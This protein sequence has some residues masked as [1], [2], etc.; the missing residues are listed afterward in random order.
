MRKFGAMSASKLLQLLR[1]PTEL[2]ASERFKVQ[3]RKL[4]GIL[5]MANF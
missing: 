3:G 4:S 2:L 5:D 1:K